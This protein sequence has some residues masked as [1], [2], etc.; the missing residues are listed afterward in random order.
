MEWK[1]VRRGMTGLVKSVRRVKVWRTALMTS[2]SHPEKLFPCQEAP[3]MVQLRRA[4]RFGLNELQPN[5]E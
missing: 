2:V 3:Q 1:S 5:E 4:V